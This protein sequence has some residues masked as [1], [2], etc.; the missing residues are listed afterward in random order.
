M[1]ACYIHDV[2][3]EVV[4]WTFEKEAKRRCMKEVSMIGKG[5]VANGHLHVFC[6]A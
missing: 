4:E 2:A 5:N 1:N 6:T 3:Q